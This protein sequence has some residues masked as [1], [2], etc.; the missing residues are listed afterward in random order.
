[1][2]AAIVKTIYLASLGVRGDFTYDSAMLSIWVVT[3]QY[4]IVIAACIP[5]LG[6]LFKM[7]VQHPSTRKS[8]SSRLRND[9]AHGAYKHKDVGRHYNRGDAGQFNTLN[10]GHGT[11]FQG[12]PL[13]E[14]N[15]TTWTRT[16]PDDDSPDEDAG[17]GDG[18]VLN[19]THSNDQGSH[20]QS[21]GIMKTLEVQVQ[22]EVEIGRQHI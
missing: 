17:S 14:Y 15:V 8:K 19:R 4:M 18:I 12:Y 22:S 7:I 5:P 1:M 20:P 6:P 10:S 3:E 2:A 9:A 13:A 16:R 11:D 21:G